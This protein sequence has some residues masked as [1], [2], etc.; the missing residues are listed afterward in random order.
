MSAIYSTTKVKLP[1]G[2]LASG[3]PDLADV[4][5][6]SK[7]YEDLLYAWKSWRDAVGPKIKKIYPQ[8]VSLENKAAKQQGKL[9]SFRFFFI[10]SSEGNILKLF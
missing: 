3:E 10:S 4:M 8:L 7:N 1:D 6:N 5:R 2:T 9:F